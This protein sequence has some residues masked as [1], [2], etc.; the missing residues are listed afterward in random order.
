MKAHA[1]HRFLC[2]LL[3]VL[4]LVSLFPT[5]ALA[6]DTVTSTWEKVELDKITADD[7]VAITMT[8]DGA[9]YALPTAGKGGQGQPL[10]VTAAVDGDKLSIEGGK[11]DFGWTITASDGTYSIVNASGEHLYVTA[12]NNGVRIGTPQ[13]GK[14]V[15]AV[16]SLPNGYFAA[17]DGTDVRNIGVYNNADWRCYKP[18][19]DGSA[20]ANIAGE[21]LGFWKFVSEIEPEPTTEP[22]EKTMLTKLDGAPADGDTVAIYHPTSSTVLTGTASDA[23]LAGAAATLVEE[24]IEQTDAMAMLQV[25]VTE[26]VYVFSLDGKVLTSAPT[27]N[28]LSFAE[29]AESDLAKWTLEQQADGTWYLKNVGANY[30][31]NYNQALEY[32]NGFTTYGV[33]ENNNAYKFA[34]YAD[35]KSDPVSG[36]KTGDTVAIFNDGNGKAVTAAASGTRLAAADAKLDEAGALTGENI[37]LFTV[38][39]NDDGTVTFANDGKVLT[40][41]ATGSSLTL[42]ATANEYSLWVIEDAGDGLFFVKNANAKYNNNAQYL[43]YYN[44]FTTYGKSASAAAKAYA[45]SFRAVAETPVAAVETPVATP[46]AGAVEAGTEVTF[47][48]AT[49]G[50]VISYST[51]NGETWTEGTSLTVSEAVTVLVK[52]MKDGAESET[53]SFAY[54]IKEPEPSYNTVKEALDGEN[55]ASFTVKGVV[56]MVDGRNVYV[57]DATGGICLYLSAADSSIGLGDTV[58]GSGAKTVYRGLPELSSAKIEKSEGLTLSAKDTTIGAL[59]TADVCTY[60]QLKGLE[61]TEVYDNNGSYSNPNITV[62]DE[63]D[64]T[65]Q[66]YKAVV[67]KTDGA[68]DVKVGDKVDV[69]AA[70]GINNTT[71]QL[72]NTVAAEITPA[73]E[74]K[75]GIVTDLADLTDGAKVVILNPANNMALSQ[76]Y[77]GNYNSGV[78]VQLKDGKLSGYG[79]SEVWTVGVNAD[80]TYTF[81]TADGKKIS[82][83]AS[84]TS[85]PLDEANPNWKLL[86]VADKTDCF[87]IENTG[88]ANARMEWYADRGY[89][90]AYYNSNTGDLFIQQFYLVG[91]EIPGGD[92]GDVLKDGDQVV[93][94]NASAEGVLGVDDTGLG[95]SLANIPAAISDGKAEPENGAY[96]FTVGKD[97]ENYTFQTG[98][99]Y[100]ATNDAESLFLSD[101]LT[102]TGE[103][104]A[105]WTLEAKGDGYLIKSKTAR[106][107]NSGVVC[108][109]FFSGAFSGW[110]FKSTDAAIFVFQFYPIAEGVKTLNDVVNDPKVNFTSADS[111]V[112]QAAYEG[113]FTLDDLTPAEQIASVAVTCNG[114]PVETQNKEKSYTFTIPGDVTAAAAALDIRVTVTY[115]DGGSYAGALSV[116]VK[117]EPMFENLKPAP[118]SETG[119]DKTPLISADVKNVTDAASVEMTV[120]G[121][122]VQAA[123]KDGVVSY[124][125]DKALKDGRTSVKLTVTRP[126]GVKGE[127]S[128]TFIVG[129]ATEQLFFGQLHSHTTYSDGSGSLETALDYVK[130]LPESANVQFVAFTDHSNY[131][132][133]TGAANPEGALYDMSL[134]SQASQDTWNT[135]RKTVADFNAAQADIVAIAGFEMTWSGGPGHINTF[136]SPGIVSRNN[137]T[138]NNKTND[139]GMKAYYALLDQPEGAD[140]LSQFNH[141]GKTFGNFTDFSYWD[142]VTDSRIFMVEVGNGEGQIGAG[143]YYPSYEQY[144]MALDKG[145]H[146]APTN[147]QD[148]HKGR[149]GN[150]NDARDVILTDDFSE[151]GIYAALRAM[152]MYATEDK[153]L[154][155]YYNVNEQPLG[156]TISEVPEKLELS[157]Q[158]SDPDSSDQ[159]SKVEVVVNSG[160]VVHTWSSAEEISSGA[161]SATLAPDYSYYF[162]RVTESDGDLAVTAPVWVGETL[163]LGISAFESETAMPVTGEELTLKTTLFN[164]EASA[165]TVKS[166]TYT[167]GGSKVLGSDTTG[168][169]VPA[170]GTLEIPFNYTPDQARVMT[171]TAT[172]VLEQ[173][174]KEFTFT[175]DLTLDVQNAEDLVYIGIDASHYNEYVAGNYKD[176]MGNFANL[177]A[178]HAVRTVYLKTSEELIA[179]CGN[180]KYKAIILTAPSRRLAAAQ[181]DPKSYSDAELAALKAFNEAGGTV[182]VA[183]WSD[184]YENYAVITGNPEIK[185][186]AAAQNDILAALGSSLRIADDATHDDSLNGG[187]TQRLYF[188]TYNP[189]NPL[190][191][192]VVVDPE[193]PNDRAYSEVFSHYGGASIYAVDASGAAVSTLPDTVSPAVYGHATTYSKDSDNDGLGGDT[194]P[195]YAYAEGDNRLLIT[196]TEQLEGKGMIVVSGAAFMSNFEVQASVSDGSSDA[197][198]QKNYANYKVCENLISPM[199]TAKVSD[200]SAVRAETEDGFKFTIEGTVTSN[201]SGYDKDTAFFDCIYVQ[202]ETG[203]ICCF[204]VSGTFKVGDKVRVTG[205][206]DFYQGEPELQVTSISIIGSGEVSPKEV[207]AKDVTSRDVEGS[208][209]TVKG[210]VESF[211]LENGL[212]Q[213]IMVKDAK[214]DVVRVFIDG[215]ITTGKDVENIADG[216]DITVTGLASYDDTFNAP[217]G[218]FPRIRIRDRADVVCTPKSNEPCPGDDTCPSIELADVDRSPES[219]YHEAVDWA[220]VNG[221]T[222]GTSA[223]TFSP[224][225]ACTRAQAVTFLWRAKGSPEPTATSCDFTDV[226]QD[227]YY[228]KAVLWAVENGVTQGVDATHFAPDAKCTRAHIVTFL[229]RAEKGAAGAENPFV[230]VPAGE[231]YTEAVLWAVENG[232]TQGMDATHFA[233]GN[234]CTRAQIVTFLYRAEGK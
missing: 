179:A 146:V 96:V 212:V 129:E 160:K 180:E 206:T 32:Y 2:L 134:A 63:N 18:T 111:V 10:A 17:S 42:E 136:N 117:D 149:W 8:K 233:P 192:G 200:I 171:V 196:A 228:F 107:N 213:T 164:S 67:G 15:T 198:T 163:K 6:A 115:T 20:H 122:T 105:Y 28:G 204:P 31:G 203:G 53:A 101:T 94:Y 106:Y 50:A 41:G 152:R 97:G 36:L 29:D 223:T 33:K 9:T 234:D 14:E 109:E 82:M 66:I 12:T 77:S 150:A 133:T 19:A 64:A 71:L 225:D 145:W 224:D 118:G 210:T 177:A 47:I 119:A 78:P 46:D 116:T 54:T 3:T 138:L 194:V 170:S 209:I 158:V 211:A 185:H 207:S 37:A 126:D 110:T 102:D 120:N 55:N 99:K 183:G 100:L 184:Y 73:I 190:M 162:I 113:A 176:S 39:V 148:N 156:S 51:D 205:T 132:D 169:T 75:T 186:M 27:G 74:A 89:W 93:I 130:N 188:S 87:Y 79:A 154:E 182:V 38:T 215:Y 147:N 221:V 172:V 189:D 123:L 92:E 23:K 61:V 68:W 153:N 13:S 217:D 173:D 108:I 226:P 141:P 218:P 59:T 40:S 143:G 135:Y 104:C 4:M 197:D 167:T 81:A 208:L 44:T 144:I 49:E 83:A 76:T 151:E 201:A 124:R 60:V 43:E 11:T 222:K 128:W 65:I 219:W 125:P 232:I 121:E 140:T 22:A 187:Q 181:S 220:F 191:Q 88:R 139:A 24:Q 229:Y 174:G 175:K 16:F 199:N 84:Y 91:D 7:V 112:K 202:D 69:K 195:L 142:A 137:T 86:P 85:M 90:S 131:F 45:M 227:A 230:D 70:V 1:K 62:K 26:G 25:S 80:G 98:G 193:H 155:L 216:C 231:W 165:A 214:G 21:T 48:C 157:V 72:R 168:Y 58:V 30:N 34:F 127:K 52:A 35:I 103:S 166:I 114:E 95:A 178:E 56:T 159:I 5:A 161:L 57:Q